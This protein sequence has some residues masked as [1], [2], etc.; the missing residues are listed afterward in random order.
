MGNC[1]G[2]SVSGIKAFLGFG[3]VLGDLGEEFK[4]RGVLLWVGCCQEAGVILIGFLNAF[5]LEGCRIG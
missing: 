5:D 1:E 3:L 4:G 2:T